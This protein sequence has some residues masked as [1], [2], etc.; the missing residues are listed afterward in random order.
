MALW[1]VAEQGRGTGLV[2]YVYGPYNSKAEYLAANQGFAG[3]TFQTVGNQNG[4][5]N[6]LQA[7]AEANLLNTG[8]ATTPTQYQPTGPPANVNQSPAAVQQRTQAAGG[9]TGINPLDII[10]KFNLSSWV[11]RI[12]EI[13]L[14][15]V[16][17]GVGIARITGAQN[18]ISNIVKTKMPLPIPV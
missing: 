4:Y 14:G 15:I 2:A 8:S 6:Q 1:F 16:L 12:G 13:L 5:P 3:A 10:G 7:Q 9:T 17:V 18:A 11:L